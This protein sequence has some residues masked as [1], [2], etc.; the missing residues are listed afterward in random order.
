LRER[1]WRS[2]LS[3]R[4]L[5]A[6]L[7]LGIFLLFVAAISF[8]VWGWKDFSAPVRVA[9]PF[10]FTALFFGLGWIVR[11]KTHLYR[12][13]IALSA[14]AALLIPIDHIPSMPIM[15]RRLMAGRILADHLLLVW[16]YTSLSCRSRVVS[17]AISPG[18]RLAV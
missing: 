7:F 18:S 6:L 9:I 16:S 11:I 4:T 3:E 10:G 5:Q 8:V 15:V 1:L 17:L 13:A 12:S 2:I 14:I